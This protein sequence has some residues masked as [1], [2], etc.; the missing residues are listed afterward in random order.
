MTEWVISVEGSRGRPSMHF[1]CSP[2]S[3]RKFERLGFRCLVPIVEI[4]HRSKTP[5][6]DYLVR[7]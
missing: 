6:L 2:K 5:S 4:M 1:R 7:S 3:R